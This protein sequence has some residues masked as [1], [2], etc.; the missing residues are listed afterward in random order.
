MVGKIKDSL[1]SSVYFKLSIAI[2]ICFFASIL[3]IHKRVSTEIKKRT[4]AVVTN[5]SE[6]NIQS[7]VNSMK[8]Y[9]KYMS[10]I[11]M[12]YETSLSKKIFYD[13]ISHIKQSDHSINKICIEKNNFPCE[14]YGNIQYKYYDRNGHCFLDIFLPIDKHHILLMEINLLGLHEKFTKIE[15][16]NYAYVTISRQG[17]YLYH[18]DIPQIGK[19]V[20]DK[21]NER[22]M[23]SIEKDSIIYLK[24]IYLDIPVYRYYKPIKIGGETWMFTA[25]MPNLGLIESVKNTSNDFLIITLIGIGAF[26][27]VFSLDIFRWR[28]ELLRNRKIEQQNMN[29]KLKDEQYKQAMAVAELEHLKRGLKPHFLFNSLGSLRVLIDKDTEEAKKF[30]NTLSN[31]YRYMLK[32]ENQQLVKLSDELKFTEDYISLQSV[33]FTNRIITN[34]S[35]PKEFMKYDV[36]PVSLQLLVDNCIKHTCISEKEPLRIN[37]YVENGMLVVV[38]NYNPREHE[39]EHSGMGI[40]NLRKRYS[41]LTKT[42]CIFEIK[43]GYY[44]AEIPLLHI[45]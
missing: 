17:V 12:V 40:E 41:F 26:L 2:L 20:K 28:K 15:S 10:F 39:P 6:N 35:V 3:Y 24:S 43:N 44:F 33:R 32:Q 36:L 11:K 7:C 16:L 42:K 19:Y 38:N 5:I 30:T 34:V 21:T 1:F 18:P 27:A 8:E 14:K 29:L 9:I 31:L 22:L 4:V 25:N 45:L 13:A 37:I 23:L